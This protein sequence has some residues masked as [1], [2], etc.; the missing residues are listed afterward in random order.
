MTQYF[1]F[2]IPEPTFNDPIFGET[3]LND[4][5]Q[6]AAEREARK[7]KDKLEDELIY[8]TMSVPHYGNRNYQPSFLDPGNPKRNAGHRK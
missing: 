4:L 7:Q 8:K 1:I 6:Q 3:Y 2:C 5:K